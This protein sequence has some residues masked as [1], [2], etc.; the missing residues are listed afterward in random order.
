MMKKTVE[1]SKAT[2]KSL[3]IPKP[4]VLAVTLL[5]SM[6]EENLREVG[7]IGPVEERVT[8]LAELAPGKLDPEQRVVMV[9]NSA[10]RS[11]LAVGIM[12]RLNF[13]K[14]ASLDGGSE[15]WIAAGL[16]TFG[17]EARQAAATACVM[18]ESSKAGAGLP[19]WN[20]PSGPSLTP[21][22][23]PGDRG[24]GAE[25]ELLAVRFSHHGP[26]RRLGA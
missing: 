3:R 22:A 13:K 25:G 11:S 18:P 6:D 17:P 7:L 2:A 26:A 15:A 14:V 5:T 19:I 4:L 12:E 23:R 8:H 24:A 9:C 16:P 20:A 21:R 10:F 1:T